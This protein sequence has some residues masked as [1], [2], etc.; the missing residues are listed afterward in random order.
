[1]VIRVNHGKSR[2]GST[3][4]QL[5][6]NTSKVSGK[7]RAVLRLLKRITVETRRQTSQQKRLDKQSEKRFYTKQRCTN[8]P[9]TTGAPCHGATLHTGKPQAR[10]R[11]TRALEAAAAAAAAADDE[12]E[13][14]EEDDAGAD[15]DA[16]DGAAGEAGVVGEVVHEVV[17]LADGVVELLAG[18]LARRRAPPQ[19][20]RPRARREWRGEREGEEEEDG[21]VA[22]HG[23]CWMGT[24]LGERRG[25]VKERP[26]LL[27]CEGAALLDALL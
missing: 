20:G 10:L 6:D 25:G 4:S 24:G 27:W 2:R 11:G 8:P 17:G 12:Q 16:D 19:R 5:C 26:F 18:G 21:E 14:R 15:G 22:E 3:N 23:E 9:K 7:T 13:D 1:M